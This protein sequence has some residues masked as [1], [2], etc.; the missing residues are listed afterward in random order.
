M[1]ESQTNKYKIGDQFKEKILQEKRNHWLLKS[2]E[3]FLTEDGYLIGT[4]FDIDLKGFWG[5]D[6]NTPS[7]ITTHVSFIDVPN[8]K[9]RNLS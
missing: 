5:K 7:N 8:F 3:Y 1:L 9:R 2:L 6:T 4:I